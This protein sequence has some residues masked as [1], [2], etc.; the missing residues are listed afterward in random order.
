MID[1]EQPD[2]TR[3]PVASSR[4]A[5]AYAPAGAPSVPLV[6]VIT[7]FYNTDD[8][9]L[10]TAQSLLAQSFQ[11]FEW[12]IV[13]DGSTDEAAL[14][15]LRAVQARDARI[16]VVSQANAGPAAARNNAVRHA[17]GRYLCLLDSD[18]ML[19][20]TFI[21]KCVWFLES[22]PEFAFCNAWSVNFGDETFLWSIGFERGRAHLDA[23]SGP[24]IAIVRRDA[25]EAAGG[26]D[27]SI[28]LGHEDWDFWL[29]LANAGYWGHTLPEYLSWYRK[30]SKGRFAQVM[31]AES[32]HREFQAFIA[33]KYAGLRARFPAPSIKLPLPFETPA[34]DIPFANPLHKPAGEKRLL[35]LVPWMV[36]GGADRVNLE[37]M[38]ALQ[39]NGYQVSICATLESYHRWLPEF[40]KLT[41]DVFVLPSFLRRADYPRFL[42]YLIESR[43]IDIVMMSHCTFGY[44]ALPY[45]RAHFPGVTFVDL[46]HVEEPHWLNGGHPRFAVGYQDML[47]LNLVTTAHLRDWMVEHGANP[48]RI[49]V[50]YS[51]I[52]VAE[53]DAAVALDARTPQRGDGHPPVIVF[54]GRI[55]AQKRPQFLADIL[56]SLAAR[57]IA[58]EAIVIGDGELRPALEARLR[59]EGLL[60]S[61]RMPGTVGHAE[62]LRTLARADVFLLPSEYEG[63]SVALFEA[64]GMGV[65]PVTAAVGG[66]GEVVGPDT[67]F[68]IE[69]SEHELDDYVEALAMLLTDRAAR[70]RMGRAARQRILEH[71]SLPVTTAR[72]VVTLDRACALSADAPR[73]PVAAGYAQEV[74]TLAVEYTRMTGLA[75]YLWG[76]Q[77]PRSHEANGRT[78]R[79]APLRWTQRSLMT[80]SASPFGALLRRSPLAHRWGRRVM[81]KIKSM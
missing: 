47:D 41:P 37:W 80:L 40:T 77:H 79:G 27:E 38:E 21:E 51:G 36:T 72:L 26:F 81:A 57:G 63:I 25:F 66:Q 73:L 65:V 59:A 16:K 28:R 46:C 54:G 7:P 45:L 5:F 70:E 11:N 32:V 78:L 55:C 20:P 31:R 49:A 43:R 10:E 71:F 9:F 24:P 35:L 34:A 44:L 15:R 2:F 13:D 52:D 23:N 3:T 64:M 61:V 4:P 42:R 75:D 60:P 22:N 39:H 56:K 6:S 29:A 68:L 50:C 17:A 18:D 58:F 76:Q 74:A 30:R 48:D 12:M 14:A 53:L 62:W 1:P 8:V 33:R 67:G 69:R 19:E